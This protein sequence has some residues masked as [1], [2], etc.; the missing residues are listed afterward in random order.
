[1]EPRLHS[2]PSYL[3]VWLTFARNSL[4]RELTF[5]ANFV[6][7]VITRMFW[8][9][10]QIVLFEIIYS[11]VPMIQDWNRYEYFA[12]MATGM[13]INALVEAFFMSN[14]ANLSELIRTG[15]LD[16]V[17]LKPIDT[18]FL[19]SLESVDYAMVNQVLL[20]LA[21][22][23]YSLSK[24]AVTITLGHVGM[25]LLY[26]AVGVT[27]FYS[28]MIAL[29]STSVWMGR[30]QGLYDFWFYVTSF[31]RYPQNFY[32]QSFDGGLLWFTLSFVL[33]ILLVVTVPSRIL[34]EKA[35][36]PSAIVLIIAPLAAL[37]ALVVS[38]QIFTWSLS[39]YRSASS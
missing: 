5:R 7:E 16:F 12:F 9:T 10:A 15:N 13:L 27:F 20:S 1:M 8:F 39:R 22:L 3:R 2:R 17:L 25:Y 18:Q 29:A 36:E 14:I 6:I 35:L 23:W 28:L 31:A 38:R 30:N 32:R 19:V 26:V 33:P 34:L 11:K 24:L 4:V 21:L 37:I